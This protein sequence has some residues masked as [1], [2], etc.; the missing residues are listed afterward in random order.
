MWE[1][2]AIQPNRVTTN[3]MSAPGRRKSR[4][5]AAT[6]PRISR[7]RPALSSTQFDRLA[8]V[9]ECGTVSTRRKRSRPRRSPPAPVESGDK[10]QNGYGKLDD[11]PTQPAIRASERQVDP[12]VGVIE[13]HG[14]NP[15]QNRRRSVP[16]HP[17]V[18]QEQPNH[19]VTHQGQIRTHCHAYKRD[20]PQSTEQVASVLHRVTA[21][22]AQGRNRDPGER[23]DQLAAGRAK[24]RKLSCNIQ[25]NR[26]Q[27]PSHQKVI[28]IQCSS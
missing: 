19:I 8:G 20:H 21:K 2:A 6:R 22:A 1:A 12:A 17:I 23:R 10:Q 9:P 16:T 4:R 13:K 26:A 27:L 25:R 24:S 7:H 18:G 5:R 28:C 11:T 3:S 15:G 14:A